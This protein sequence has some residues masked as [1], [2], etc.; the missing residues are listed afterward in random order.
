MRI[1]KLAFFSFLVFFAILT[2]F[3]LFIPSHIRLTKV[4]NIQGE[5][6][7]IFALIKNKDQWVKWHPA[8]TGNLDAEQQTVFQSIEAEL[9][10]ES[11]SV[12]QMQWQQEGRKAIENGWQ[13]Y[14]PGTDSTI[15]QW[16]MD[17][18]L[19]WYPWQKFG[20]L[21]YEKN[22]GQM[23]EQGLHNLKTEIEK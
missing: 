6:D 8:F 1:I 23:M 13:L 18:N 16:Y 10:S 5:K 21:F 17:F 4:V 3:S 15:L 11:D 20:S 19:P 9:V 12:L 22:Y 14:H 2:G 7:S